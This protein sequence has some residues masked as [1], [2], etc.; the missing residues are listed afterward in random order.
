M[1]DFD[2]AELELTIKALR[3]SLEE[4]DARIQNLKYTLAE[5]GIEEESEMSDEWEICVNELSRLKKLS[6]TAGGLDDKEVKSFE[7]LS[8]RFQA[9][10]NGMDKKSPK[11]KEYDIK[12]LLKV[13]DG[14]KD[15]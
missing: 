7:I 13:V 15:N 8:K 11:G 3:K 1:V 9:I 4:K 12:D 10:Q 14:E 5:Y 2:K 6:E